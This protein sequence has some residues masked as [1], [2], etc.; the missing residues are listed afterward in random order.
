MAVNFK[1]IIINPILFT[2]FTIGCLQAQFI[3]KQ[4]EHTIP[5]SYSLIPE[6]VEIESEEQE[7]LFFMTIPIDKLKQAASEEGREIDTNESSI[8]VDG[9]NFAVEDN[10][11]MGRMTVISNA[12]DGVMYMVRWAQKSVVVMTP[13]DLKKIEEQANAAMEESI[14]MMSPEMQAQ[15]REAM[16]QEKQQKSGAKQ[17]A[18]PTGKKMSING[19][20]CE[21]YITKM[22]EGNITGIWAAPDDMKITAAAENISEKFSKIFS[23]GEDEETDEWSLVKGKIP[24]EVREMSQDMSMG[25]PSFSITSIQKIE[26]KTPPA[27]KFYVPGEKDGFTHGSFSD[28]M[29]QMMQG[30]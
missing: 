21:L 17:A 11:E 12:K 4:A 23:M 3:I 20:N 16:E 19:F 18:N 10:S 29:K 27:D 26:R 14:K 13:E 30:N 8:Y 2:I 5:I 7:A 6:D 9:D 1:S 28:M 22:E 24:I 15:I 25:E